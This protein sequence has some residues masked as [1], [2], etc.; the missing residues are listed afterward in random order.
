M[1]DA[2]PVTPSPS[3]ATAPPGDR[4]D[5]Q[6]E[7]HLAQ[8][9]KMSTTAGVTNLD[10]VAVNQT[11]IVAAVLGVLSATALLGWILLAIPLVGIA[12][13]IVAIRQV[14]DSGGT[15]TGKGLAVLGLLLSVL[16]GGGLVVWESMALAAVRGDENRIAQTLSELGRDVKAGDYKSAYA[17]FTDDFQNRVKLEQFEAV[18]KSA[19]RPLALGSLHD[20]QWNEVTPTFGSEAGARTA[21]IKAIMKFERAQEERFDVELRQVGGKWLIARLPSFFPERKPT[22][23]DDVFNDPRL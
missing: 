14:N 4:S 13:A 3:T 5:A 10:Y 20:V 2:A 7:S 16:F 19:Q 11:A 17:L 6:A 18:W 8:L 23:A 22:K 9:H 1:P 15:Q 12:F 21:V